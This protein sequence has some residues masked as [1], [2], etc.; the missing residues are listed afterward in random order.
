MTLSLFVLIAPLLIA[1]V[2]PWL[3]K[4]NKWI[5]PVSYIFL[6]IVCSVYIY[7]DA[8]KYTKQ[9][10]DRIVALGYEWNATNPYANVAEADI[11]EIKSLEMSLMGVG[12]QMRGAMSAMFYDFLLTLFFGLSALV[13]WLFVR[14]FMSKRSITNNALD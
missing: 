1:M 9:N 5:L 2:L 4:R 8:E 12:W 3:I 6:I 11:D 13:R 14:Y 7:K 10:E